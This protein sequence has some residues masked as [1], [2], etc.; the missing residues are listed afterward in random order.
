[1]LMLKKT[2][3]FCFACL[4]FS[5]LWMSCEPAA[6]SP[7]DKVRVHVLGDIQHL[8][9]LTATGATSTSV[10]FQTHQLLYA[11]N[12]TTYEYEPVLAKE[13]AKV[14]EEDGVV[15]LDFEI[16]PEAKWDNGK[17]ITAEDL[18]FS[19]KLNFVPDAD[20][21]PIRS[22]LDYV[23]DILVDSINNK[24]FTVVCKRAYMSAESSIAAN[25]YFMPAYVYDPQGV[26]E[27][28]SL[29]DLLS[30]DEEIKKKLADDPKLKE[31]AKFFNGQQ[32]K[33]EINVG[34]GPYAF[35]KWD[36]NQ[37]LVLK[38]KDNWWGDAVEDKDANPW[39]RGYPKDIDY[40]TITDLNTAVVALKG[41][42]I[43][44]MHSVPP[45]QFVE[46]LSK[47]DDF[48]N[49]FFLE[50]PPLLSYDYIG[51]NMK[52]PRLADVKVR[53]AIAH[54]M[55]VDE[56]V[57]TELY[58]LGH[59]VTT[60]VHPLFE[61]RLNTDLVPYDF[62]VEKAKTLLAEAGWK[63]LDEDGVLDKEIEGEMYSLKLRIDYN[64]GNS[65]RETTCI[66]LK[67]AARKAGIEIEV[68]PLEWATYLDKH[69][70][71]DFDM[72]VA[73]WV[74]SPVESDPKQIWHTESYDGSSNY[75]GYGTP[76]SDAM[77]EKLRVTV[78]DAARF[79]IY[80]ELQADI[81]ATV[82]YVFLI[83]R[84]NTV[85][86]SKKYETASSTGLRSGVFANGMKGVSVVDPG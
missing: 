62:N 73:G 67:D 5:L 79:Q 28:Y 32:F 57:K 7:S 72:Y 20:T 35:V 22:Y 12:P 33:R 46:D 40:I 64:N 82:P 86:V 15:K 68:L 44:A 63:D 27:N 51:M 85:C 66:L 52:D 56:L 49:E 34:S 25:Q 83:S 84:K 3:F 47:S 58:G 11:L 55:D 10:A 76:K 53:K 21:G 9:T 38:R 74:A 42:S 4:S 81:H 16:R 48:K 24:K 30:E 8:N 36:T 77:I 75:V 50:N 43:D 41:K 39:L 1:M 54:L 14:Y 60:F 70:K 71:H 69:N 37:R 19:M 26:L 78:D 17:A 59:R 29:K 2:I 61:E 13:R 6:E 23:E 31:Y 18:I 45:K 65:R 80:K